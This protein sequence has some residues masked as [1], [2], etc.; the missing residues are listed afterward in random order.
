MWRTPTGSGE[1]KPRLPVGDQPPMTLKNRPRGAYRAAL[2]AWAP[3]VAQRP[4]ILALVLSLLLVFAVSTLARAQQPIDWSAF[5]D[6]R[7]TTLENQ[8]LDAR[9]RVVESDMLEVKWL[10]R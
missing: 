7:I 5:S 10:S 6:R 9:I 1:C 2:S 3:K 8:N 4:F